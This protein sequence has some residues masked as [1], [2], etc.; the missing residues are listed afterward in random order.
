MKNW[1]KNDPSIVMVIASRRNALD[2][3]EDRQI[4][5]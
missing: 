3:V 5:L 4:N 1:L 2:R